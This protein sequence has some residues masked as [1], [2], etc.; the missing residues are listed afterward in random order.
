MNGED[1][2]KILNVTENASYEEIK[3]SYRKLAKEN[4]PDKGGNKET[5]QRIQVAYET[6]SDANKKQEYDMMRTMGGGPNFFMPD[7]VRGNDI[8]NFFNFVHG[9]GG[10]VSTQRNSKV[11]KND[12]VYNL[13]INLQDVYHGCQKTFNI[14]RKTIC[15]ACKMNCHKCQGS[16]KMQLR[17][18]I[19]P[20]LQF[21]NQQC[22][23]C[24]GKGIFRNNMINCI[25]CNNTGIKQKEKFIELNIPRGVE[26]YKR[27]VYEGWGEQ[28]INENEVSGDFIIMIDIEPHKFFEKR[29]QLDLV[30]RSDITIT[31]S[32]VGKDLLIPFFENNNEPIIINTSIFGII[33]QMKEYILFDKGL[34][35]EKGEK[36]NMI[37]KFNLIYPDEDKKLNEEQLNLLK[38]VFRSVNLL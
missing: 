13:K 19:G 23:T 35:N 33:N 1:Y 18:Q 38:D 7:N 32:I 14:M 5:F 3:F 6:L 17:I 37:L 8:F 34:I 26:N 22:D 29:N 28:G 21:M 4:H 30:Y 25:E 16:G 11:R 10:N 2:Y 27:Y 15:N 20:I 24:Q 36:G 31:E 9:G 12:E